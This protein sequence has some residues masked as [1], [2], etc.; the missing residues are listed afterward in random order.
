MGKTNR[1]SKVGDVPIASMIDVIFLLIIFFVVTATIDNEIQDEAVRLAKA[2]YGKPVTPNR[3]A[4]TVNVHKDGS[5]HVGGHQV[6]PRTFTEILQTIGSEYGAN[7]PV[8]IRGDKEA[9]HGN[10]KEVMESVKKTGLYRVNIQAL[11][12]E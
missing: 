9:L 12:E 6:S 7:F 2:P 4:V 10:I 11:K 3:L 8:V 5:L 1:K